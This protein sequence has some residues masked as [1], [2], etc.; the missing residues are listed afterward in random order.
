MSRSYLHS[1]PRESIW[2]SSADETTAIMLSVPQVA[3]GCDNNGEL[4][5]Q[6]I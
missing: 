4:C 1:D 3:R 6:K 5:C 2:A